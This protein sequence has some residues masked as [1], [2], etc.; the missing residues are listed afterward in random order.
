MGI[1]DGGRLMLQLDCAWSP[2]SG[3]AETFAGEV[4]LTQELVNSA[5]KTMDIEG[6]EHGAWSVGTVGEEDVIQVQVRRE[7]PHQWS[8]LRLHVPSPMRGATRISVDFWIETLGPNCWYFDL[9]FEDPTVGRSTHNIKFD[10]NRLRTYGAQGEDSATATGIGSSHWH[11]LE[12]EIERRP[13]EKTTLQHSIDGE[14][15]FTSQIEVPPGLVGISLGKAA[16]AFSKAKWRNIIV[17]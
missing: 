9:N 16:Y 15:V 4:V 3:L 8:R 17:E 5:Q 10:G 1:E 13:G 11:Q 14:L 7:P 12:I 2:L 6:H